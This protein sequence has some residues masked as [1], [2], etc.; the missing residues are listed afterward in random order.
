[1]AKS[2]ITALDVGTTKISAVI[3]EISEE[4]ELKIL[5][6]GVGPSAG[7]VKG[8]ITNI[9]AAVEAIS[10]AIERAEKTA[11][12]TIASAYVGIAGPPI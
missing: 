5:G 12:L 7:L 6:V 4:L 2:V 8:V 3:A 11:G 9:P 10:S 1:M